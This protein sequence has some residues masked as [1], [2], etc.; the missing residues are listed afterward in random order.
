MAT[1]DPQTEAEIWL[2]STLSAAAPVV[3]VFEDR[4]TTHPGPRGAEYPRLTYTCLTP[5]DSLLLVGTDIFWDSMRFIVRGI[6]EGDDRTI[7][8]PGVIAIQD[9]IHGKWGGTDNAYIVSCVRVRPY[10]MFEMSDSIGYTH[11]GGEYLIR[12][13]PKS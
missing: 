11:I 3:A 2:Q 10:Y 7:L 6:I 4:I 13:R 8:R 5:M 1:I 12:L 9:A